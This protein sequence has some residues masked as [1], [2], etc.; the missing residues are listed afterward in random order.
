MIDP[1]DWTYRRRRAVAIAGSVLVGL[2]LVWLIGG[3][4]SDGSPEVDDAANVEEISPAVR[5]T[6]PP[7]SPPPMPSPTAPPSSS[8]TASA[9]PVPPAG[10][11]QAH[12]VP[13]PP[14][15]PAPP[16]PGPGQVAA[17]APAPVGPPPPPPPPGPCQDGALYLAAETGQPEY[18]V[19]QRPAL[20]LVIVNI[21]QVPCVRD[22][23][24]KLRELTVHGADGRR[25]WSSAD[26]YTDDTPD[27]RVIRPG[28]RLT[29][30]VTWAGRTS[31]PGCP[32][33]R[34][35]VPAGQYL[36]HAKLGTLTSAGVPL[37]LV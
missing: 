21:G 28:E 25:L 5:S 22:I 14:G 26:C 20:R 24:R 15:A 18:R 16:V 12:P 8:S 4:F 17:P 3:L 2:L 36:I 1:K 6:Q 7:S 27:V 35:G 9:A 32:A 10:E 31:E 19:G 33:S 29:F 23:S 34:K 37:R 13:V 30:G 11:A